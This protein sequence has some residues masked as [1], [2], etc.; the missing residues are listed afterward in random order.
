MFRRRFEPGFQGAAERVFAQ[1]AIVSQ[2]TKVANLSRSP[3]VLEVDGAGKFFI[4]QSA[5]IGRADDVE[6]SLERRTISRHHARIFYEGGHYWL[7]DLESANGTTVN[8]K[9]T[10][11]QIL[12]D[13]DTVCFGEAKAVFHT[14]A[15]HSGPVSVPDGALEEVPEPPRDGTPTS[16]LVGKPTSAQGEESPRIRELEQEIESLRGA[17]DSKDRE[18]EGLREE[19]RVL[20]SGSFGTEAILRAGATSTPEQSDPEELAR[21]NVRLQRLTARL[22]R[23]LSENTARLKMLQERLDLMNEAPPPKRGK[24]Q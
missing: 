23:A 9:R 5:M 2:K 7:R 10:R 15:E 21:E 17:V 11:L 20:R 13:G 22:E 14:A 8:G 6:I 24:K 19:L 16:G 4:E 1:V 3:A 12:S 18:L